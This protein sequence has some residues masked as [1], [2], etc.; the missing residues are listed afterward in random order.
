[1]LAKST[2]EL[3][4][5]YEVMA[6]PDMSTIAHAS[7]ML[8]LASPASHADHS[9]S[10]TSTPLHHTAH[11]AAHH[12]KRERHSSS[13]GG[14]GGS[15]GGV[16]LRRS[17]LRLSAEQDLFQSRG[18]GVVDRLADIIQRTIA[19]KATV[20]L[21]HT[22]GSSSSSSSSSSSVA[23]GAGGAAVFEQIANRKH[24]LAGT[25]AGIRDGNA[26]GDHHRQ[27]QQQALQNDL[28]SIQQELEHEQNELHTLLEH[29]KAPATTALRHEPQPLHQHPPHQHHQ[30]E[31]AVLKTRLKQAN[32]AQVA[33]K[34]ALDAE[35]QTS[36]ALRNQ[37]L[38]HERTRTRTHTPHPTPHA[39]YAPH[40]PHTPPTTHH[41]HGRETAAL[42][43]TTASVNSTNTAAADGARGKGGEVAAHPT[44][45]TQNGQSELLSVGTPAPK[46][47]ALPALRTPNTTPSTPRAPNTPSTPS[48]GLL[49]KI[50]L[51]QEGIGM[52]RDRVRQDTQD[53]FGAVTQSHERE[54]RRLSQLYVNHT[55]N[56]T[57]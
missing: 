44:P 53:S 39:F 30:H 34:A 49:A 6:Q 11:R 22:Q 35:Q 20:S 55:L 47:R 2:V 24:A 41:L 56:H 19:T 15:G 51:L 16:A 29:A 23:G 42:A 50:Q 26:G 25:T 38:Q 46:Q 36:E 45:V 40:T 3:L 32:A 8:V 13:G 52:T 7:N 17:A 18:R 9:A 12:P 33:L 4:R 14:G 48:T 1:M 21:L 57:L 31:A 43:V 54:Q 10:H 27:Q 37:V 5:A 28:E